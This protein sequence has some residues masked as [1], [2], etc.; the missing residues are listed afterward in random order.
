VSSPLL[1][2]PI[3]PVVLR[4]SAPGLLLVAFQS[5]VSVG[6]TY[7]VGRLG[8]A[9]LAG[10]ALVFPLIMLLQMTSAGAMG[11]G[12]SSAIARALGAG[13]PDRARRLV[14][15]ALIIA[16]G[17]A[18]AFTVLL[19]L[20]AR[21]FYGLLGGE[22]ETLANAVAYSNIIFA[23]AITVWLANTLSSV[24]RGSGNM[25]GPAVTLI[26]AACIQVPLSGMLVLG[27]GPSFL[28]MP[29]LGIAGAGIAYITAFGLAG[30]AMAAMVFRRGSTLRPRA[31]DFVLEKR[32]FGDILRVG[33]LSVLNSVQT[34][35]TAVVLTGFV[36]RFGPAALAGYGVGVRLELLQIPI[37]FAIGQAL[38]VLV[39]TNVG[40]GQPERAKRIAWIGT[41]VAA[42]IC[43]AIGGT[44]A[45]FP[46]AWVGLFSSDGAVLEAGSTYLRI[47]GPFYSLLA[48]GIALYFASQGAGQMLRPVLAGTTR[49]AIVLV[50]GALVASLPAIYAVVALGITASA[51][52]LMWFVGRARW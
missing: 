46:L 20:F 32:L 51:A 39:G 28:N 40:G 4:L 8:T 14:V 27:V 1:S 29:R 42:G 35:A 2:A 24:L 10:L 44:V 52:I 47:V 15:H 23:G 26:A 36:A 22:G 41:A 25:A 6:D 34:V 21:P 9:P 3:L 30:L 11:G 7:F 17:M 19:L 13:H 16:A 45:L 31:G 43:F 5:M 33:G 38:V 12:V 50:G 18:A 48:A 49:L 37:V